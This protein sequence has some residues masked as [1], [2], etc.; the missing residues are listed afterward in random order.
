[1]MKRL[2]LLVCGTLIA[3]CSP[4]APQLK[5]STYHLRESLFSENDDPMVRG[6][7]QRLL[8]GS[9]SQRQRRAKI[10]DYYEFHW[11]DPLQRAV[12]LRFDYLQA[13]TGSQVQ[14]RRVHLPM[15]HRSLR[16]SMAITGADYQKGGRILAWK[17]SVERD[18]TTLA[19]QQSYLWK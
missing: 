7:A 5:V 19:S 17:A 9:V 11:Q 2:L 8:H 4:S 16:H 1:M 14:T 18:G 13:G 12:D 10:G 3:A 15:P 6:E